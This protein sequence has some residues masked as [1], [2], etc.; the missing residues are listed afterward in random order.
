MTEQAT[1]KPPLHERLLRGA[2]VL[3][4]LWQA[5]K[6]GECGWHLGC[7][8]KDVGDWCKAK[9]LWVRLAIEGER[10]SEEAGSGPF[11]VIEIM[12]VKEFAAARLT[13]TLDLP[14]L[15]KIAVGPKGQIP[16]ETFASLDAQ[17]LGTVL[18]VLKSFPG[19]K[20]VK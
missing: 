7:Q 13:M 2:V 3:G 20:V 14:D 11:G 9:M 17:G 4:K 12:M 18:S 8:C 10:V 5:K 16:W 1:E 6:G 19:A 15:G